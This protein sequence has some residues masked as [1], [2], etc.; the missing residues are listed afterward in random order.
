MDSP[1]GERLLEGPLW[2][3]IAGLLCADFFDEP[4]HQFRAV[5]K[6]AFERLDLAESG[7]AVNISFQTGTA[8]II[9]KLAVNI[10][11]RVFST[12]A[13]PVWIN[14]A[15]IIFQKAAGAVF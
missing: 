4:Q 2:L 11:K 14:R 1:R 6:E 15:Q 5:R 7:P 12:T 10:V 13:R 3:K 9:I 8:G